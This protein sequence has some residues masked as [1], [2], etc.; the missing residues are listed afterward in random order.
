F[1]CRAELVGEKGRIVLEE[2]F[3]PSGPPILQVQ[4]GT[5]TGGLN[6]RGLEQI[7][8]PQQD[9]YVS[10]VEDFCASIEAGKLLAPAE[11]G[12]ANMRVLES[13]LNDAKRRRA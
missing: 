13:A 8:I 2:A 10:Q 1:R 12:V 7:L 11:D 3:L 9:Q 5:S 6:D 4:R